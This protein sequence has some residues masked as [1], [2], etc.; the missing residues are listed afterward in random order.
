[1][2]EKLEGRVSYY[3]A[4]TKS[5]VQLE[6]NEEKNLVIDLM[7]LDWVI[8]KNDKVILVGNRTSSGTFRAI[9]YKNITK[10]VMTPVISKQQY[11]YL[12]LICTLPLIGGIWSFIESSFGFIFFGVLS[13]IST[14][15]WINATNRYNKLSKVHEIISK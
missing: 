7:E 6:L 13:I 4:Q 9:G 8:N 11:S 14:I 3:K 1:M 2:L 15:I 5:H 10:N 12:C